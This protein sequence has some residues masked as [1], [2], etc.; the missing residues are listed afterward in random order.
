MC[1]RSTV[2]AG[3]CSQTE[4]IGFFNPFL[5]AYLVADKFGIAINYGEFAIIRSRVVDV[6]PYAKKLDGIAVSQPIQ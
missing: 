5:D 2:S 1:K 6:L 3:A 4:R